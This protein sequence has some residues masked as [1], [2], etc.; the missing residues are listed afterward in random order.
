MGF[1]G[2][3][4]QEIAEEI[5]LVHRQVG[6]WRRRWANA[7]ERLTNIECC[8]TR[9]TLRRAIEAVLTDEPRPG[10]PSKFTPEQV[11]QILAIACEP[12]EKSS[13]RP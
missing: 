12:P 6:R 8:E 11:T 2:L 3:R 5:G 10:T 13:G 4:N 1:D 9:A 7:W